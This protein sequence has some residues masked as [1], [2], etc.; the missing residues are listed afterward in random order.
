MRSTTYK[1]GVGAHD[2]NLAATSNLATV[3]IVS[4]EKA[5]CCDGCDREL[6]AHIVA[7]FRSAS[8][9]TERFD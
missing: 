2:A 5:W 6:S 3:S 7:R 1:R 8:R 4:E 9:A